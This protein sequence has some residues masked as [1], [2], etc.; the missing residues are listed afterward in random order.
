[1]GM[2]LSL[3]GALVLQGRVSIHRHFSHTELHHLIQAA[4]TYFL[5]RGGLPVRALGS[6]GPEREDAQPLPLARDE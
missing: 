6:A 1:M 3:L 2:V 4:T 5:Y